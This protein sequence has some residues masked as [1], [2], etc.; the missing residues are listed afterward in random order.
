[1]QLGCQDYS[2]PCCY[3]PRS[4]FIADVGSS[5]TPRDRAELLLSLDP[6]EKKEEEERLFSPSATSSPS[7][8]PEKVTSYAGQRLPTEV[9]LIV[10]EHLLDQRPWQLPSLILINKQFR[11]ILQ[12]RLFEQVHLRSIE[13]LDKLIE[14]GWPPHG[15]LLPSGKSP[16]SSKLA[17]YF[18][19]VLD[20]WEKQGEF[21]E[22]LEAS[23][24]EISEDT[25]Q[26]IE[27][28]GVRT[29]PSDKD[30]QNMCLWTTSSLLPQLRHLYVDTTIMDY[31]NLLSGNQRDVIQ[32]LTKDCCD[33]C[34]SGRSGVNIHRDLNPS[35]PNKLFKDTT[36]LESFAF[37]V[38]SF[39]DFLPYISGC[40][41]ARR[42]WMRKTF[43]NLKRLYLFAT[44]G[45][46]RREGED[47]LAID[48]DEMTSVEYIVYVVVDGMGET[49]SCAREASLFS[50]PRGTMVFRN[51]TIDQP[52]DT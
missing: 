17:L 3:A 46:E 27:T 52:R 34:C 12:R 35:P 11:S 49:S 50:L 32:R 23:I 38:M 28:L 1:M 45:E 2:F 14:K 25:R 13:E 4:S 37:G 41:R 24:E 43:A 31:G 15:S 9:I 44:D 18:N 33:T 20:D 36:S 19:F 40:R 26:Q 21:Y 39:R 42:H 47:L 29:L 51:I 10:F 30:D 7:I 48:F 5:R 22:E 6:R 16:L 8:M